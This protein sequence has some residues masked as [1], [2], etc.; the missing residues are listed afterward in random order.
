MESDFGTKDDTKIECWGSWYNDG[1]RWHD[2]T[3]FRDFGSW[4]GRPMRR[5][6]VLDW[7]SER[8]LEDIDCETRS[9]V[10]GG[11]K[12]WF[13]VGNDVITP[14]SSFRDLGTYIDSDLSMRTFVTRTASAYFAT[15]RQIRSICWSTT[16]PVLQ[17]VVADTD[18]T[19]LRLFYC[20]F[21]PLKHSTIGDRAFSGAAQKAW[22]SLPPLIASS[23]SLP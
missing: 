13:T 1:V 21:I 18:A 15:L 17:S 7:I 8:R 4:A 9:T 5:N 10:F 3:G 23:P 19:R 14:V 11:V 22:N 20:R 2:K 12:C 16:R 6:S